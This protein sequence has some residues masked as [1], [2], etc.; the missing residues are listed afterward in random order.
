MN[1]QKYNPECCGNA[2]W[3]LGEKKYNKMCPYSTPPAFENTRGSHCSYIRE[4]FT[5]ENDK[6][7]MDECERDGYKMAYNLSCV[8]NGKVVNGVNCKCADNNDNCKVC[9]PKIKHD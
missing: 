2:D 4:N 5:S 9:F 6:K 1:Q 3:H 7:I 8:E